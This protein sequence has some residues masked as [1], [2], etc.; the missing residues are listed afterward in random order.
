MILAR[1]DQGKN[2]RSAVIDGR[3]HFSGSPNNG[4]TKQT[5]PLYGFIHLTNGV[6]VL[7]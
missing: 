3:L 2:S 5:K 6:R 7:Y 4:Q 1:A